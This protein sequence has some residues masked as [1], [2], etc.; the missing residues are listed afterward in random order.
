M[1]SIANKVNIVEKN[2]FSIKKY[3][4]LGGGISKYLNRTIYLL[5]QNRRWGVKPSSA[6]NFGQILHLH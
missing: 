5:M 6:V 1:L 3:F 4:S 2:K